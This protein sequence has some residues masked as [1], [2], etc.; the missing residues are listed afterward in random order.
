[1]SAHSDFAPIS[2]GVG[3]FS[4]VRQ[5]LGEQRFLRARVLRQNGDAHLSAVAF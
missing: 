5:N 2:A 4:R 1:M 3:A